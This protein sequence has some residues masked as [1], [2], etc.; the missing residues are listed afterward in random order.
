MLE[1][2]F[3]HLTHPIDHKEALQKLFSGHYQLWVVGNEEELKLAVIT[4]IE[5]TANGKA[6]NV[7]YLGGNSLK[8]CMDFETTLFE[9]AGLNNCKFVKARV[10][11]GLYRIFKKRGFVSYDEDEHGNFIFKRLREH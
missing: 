8:D 11:K 1:P 9:W 5:E 10:R 7:E 6:A 3:E 2:A 4:S